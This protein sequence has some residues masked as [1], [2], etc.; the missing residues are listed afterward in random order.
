S[1][2]VSEKLAIITYL[3]KNPNASKRNTA[4]R[5]NL[6]PKQLREWIKKKEE[7]I[8]SPQHIRRLNNGGHAKYLMLETDL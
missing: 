2:S 7:L 8:R 5:F 6:Q 1:W 4:E 3:E